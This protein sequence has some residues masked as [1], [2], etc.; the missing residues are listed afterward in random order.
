VKTIQPLQIRTEASAASDPA[1]FGFVEMLR[2]APIAQVPAK[3][4]FCEWNI[5]QML[6]ENHC[7][8]GAI[9]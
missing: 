2:F 9:S 6:R 5:L 1:S 8:D 3:I 7:K 4:A